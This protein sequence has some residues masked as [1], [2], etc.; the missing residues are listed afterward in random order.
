VE[1]DSGGAL[2]GY[3]N[4]FSQVLLN[5]L[6]NARDAILERHVQPGLIRVVL[7]HDDRNAWISV[8]D[9]GG[10]I[11]ADAL[12][13]VFEPYFSTKEKGTGIGLYM[14]KTIIEEHMGGTIEA[15]NA[16]DGAVFTLRCPR[17]AE[18]GDA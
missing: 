17:L 18:A 2:F 14:S 12:P 15:A 10:G 5:V 1:G 9:N 16:E 7:G 4:E 11:P 13:R 6:G 8:R 3:P